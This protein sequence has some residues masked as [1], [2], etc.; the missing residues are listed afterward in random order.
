M[1][2]TVLHLFR[3]VLLTL[4][5]VTLLLC[6]NSCAF[7]VQD[8]DLLL[9]LNEPQEEADMS[10]SQLIA[11]M[12]EA[13]DPKGVWYNCKSY[14]LRQSAVS[15]EKKGF[16]K[17]ERYYTTEIKFRQPTQMR[18]TSYQDGMPF[19][20]L[21]FRDNKGWII[22]D[23]GKATEYTGEGMKLFRNYVGFADPKA[24]EQT[25]FS[26]VELAVVYEEGKRYYRMVCRTA[27]PELP[28]YVKYIDATTFLT[29]R[30]ETVLCMP[31]GAHFLY[32]SESRDYRWINN[33]RM[34][35]VSVVTIENVSTQAFHTQELLIDPKLPESDFTI[36]GGTSID[37]TKTKTE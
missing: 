19:Q 3:K 8:Y 35:M 32:R 37:Y 7:M 31:D 11:R 27:D 6:L 22:N 29:D 33:V 28:P 2:M 18:Q 17:I 26:T 25:L 30:I 1:N 16:S 24:S 12:R 36:P 34:P 23:K 21:L 13:T 20:T 14:I 9:G 4:S 5:A 10:V 15:E